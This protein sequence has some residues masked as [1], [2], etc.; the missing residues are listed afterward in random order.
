VRAR[1]CLACGGRLKPVTEGGRRRRRC[2]RCGWTF[3][4][5]LV[6]ATAA[7]VVERGRVLLTRR[8]REPYAGTWDVPGGFLEAGEP[9][10]VG[11]RREVREELGVRVRSTEF[12]GFAVDSYGPRGIS[13]LAIIYRVRLGSGRIRPSDDVAEVRWFEVAGGVP[14][15]SIAFS[16]LRRALRDY[17]RDRSHRRRAGSSSA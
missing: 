8:A 10:E 7:V 6:P 4:D 9:P 14:W 17:L 12:I 13:V 5:N 15:R 2:G 3:Y 11:L 16:A 1:F